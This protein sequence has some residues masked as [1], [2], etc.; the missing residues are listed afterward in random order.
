MVPGYTIFYLTNRFVENSLPE[1]PLPDYSRPEKSS[2]DFFPW[3]RK[4]I[5]GSFLHSDFFRRIIFHWKNSSRDNFSLEISSLILIFLEGKKFF[6][7]MIFAHMILQII[8]RQKILRRCIQL[9]KKR[10]FVSL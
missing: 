7:G 6:T 4:I 10:P 3:R 5:C 9:V 8:L 2:L 1:D